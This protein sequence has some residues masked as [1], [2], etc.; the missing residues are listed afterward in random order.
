MTRRAGADARLARRLE[1]LERIGRTGSISAA[2]KALGMSYR[3]AWAAV[4]E[5]SNVSELPLLERS[6][7]G[8]GGG[9]TRL[10]AR[11]ETDAHGFFKLAEPVFARMAR[12]E[13]VT[14]VEQLK[15]ILETDRGS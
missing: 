11:L 10:T 2:A 8:K 15:D 9:G 12:R 3:G 4:A 14:S 13:F 7:G 5:L 6:T 1:L